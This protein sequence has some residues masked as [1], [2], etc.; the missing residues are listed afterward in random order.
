MGLDNIT[1]NSIPLEV[2]TPGQYFEVDASR[3]T[4]GLAGMPRRILL[5]GEKL[6]T[7]AAPEHQATRLLAE[8][9]A[10]RYFGAGSPLERM[11]AAVRKAHNDVELWA[12]PTADLSGGYGASAASGTID[13]ASAATHEAGT[14]AVYLAG[15]RVAVA[16]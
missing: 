14:L 8:G 4:S 3:A 6:S 1:F 2:L 12:M 16:V 15:R 10:V 11:A 5:I 13:I 7:G 9:D